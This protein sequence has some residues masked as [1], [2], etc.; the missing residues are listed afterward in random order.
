MISVLQNR[1]Y[2]RMFSAQV[3]SLTGTGLATMALALLA[4]D[5][6][7]DN[8]GQVLGIALAIKML[9]YIFVSPIASA[10]GERL[11]RRTFMVALDIV[12][13]LIV[14]ALPFVTDIWQIYVLIFLLQSASAGFTPTFQAV[15]PDI[16]PDE[17]DYT[18]ALS[19]AR[20]AYDLESLLSPLLAAAALTVISFHGLFIGTSV[21]FLLSA[22]LIL[23]TLLPSRWTEKTHVERIRDRIASGIRIYLKTPRLR[24]LL[25][26]TLS[27]AAASALVIVNTI[28]LVQTDLGLGEQAYALTLAVYGIGS[29]ICA[30]SLPVILKRFSDR[31]VMITAAISA[32]VAL[33]LLAISP[34]VGIWP[35]WP[36]LLLVWLIL[37]FTFAAMVTP[38]GRLLR[39]SSQDKDRASLFAAQFSLSHACW[40]I[41]YPLMGSVGS[42][43]GQTAAIAIAGILS[44]CGGL[45][46]L[47]LW[48]R[49]DTNRIEHEH[50][51]LADDHPHLR[52]AHHAGAPV[53]PFF[54][55]DLHTAW[56]RSRPTNTR[57]D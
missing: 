56:P 5:L 28:V 43:F 44:L 30:F 6:A 22:W 46:A 27:A 45:L 50:P 49:I 20:M 51:D 39:R 8:A 47:L 33:L 42:F 1:A 55:D 4:H 7:G 48:P 26:V 31:N 17:E 41:T 25:V 54:I 13:A 15:I 36:V 24:G 57:K 34:S 29:I 23:I 35:S 9:A 38:S 37:G 19:L 2:R 32:A 18:K 3:A 11:P 14:L 52:E 40:L 12:R 21:G 10:F 53:H 16:L